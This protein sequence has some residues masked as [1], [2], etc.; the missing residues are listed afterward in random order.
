MKK[1]LKE[2]RMACGVAGDGYYTERQC[3]VHGV[4]ECEE[5]SWGRDENW[6]MA[7]F[8]LDEWD[9]IE[10]SLIY[11]DSLFV[12]DLRENLRQLGFKHYPE[13]DYSEQGMQ[14]ENFVNL[15]C[16][17]NLVQ[18]VIKAGYNFKRVESTGS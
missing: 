17:D 3:V 14:G 9:T 12:K 16:T 8:H 11:S 7:N 1:E 4:L 6:A 5:L 10:D 2:L 15:D 18:E 13:I